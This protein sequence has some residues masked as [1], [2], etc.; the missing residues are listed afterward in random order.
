VKRFVEMHGGSVWVDS[1]P[2][3]GSIFFFTLPLDPQTFKVDNVL[4]TEIDDGLS[5]NGNLFPGRRDSLPE[6]EVPQNS[7]G[8]EPLVVIAEDDD[9]SRELLASVLLGAGYRVLPF[10]RGDLV[11][12]AVAKMHPYAIILDLMMPDVGGWEVL[13]ILRQHP[14]TESIPVIIV[15]ILDESSM[16]SRFNVTA[17]LT[18]P[19]DRGK[20]L[21]VLAEIGETGN[22]ISNILIVDDDPV[23]LDMLGTVLRSE[24]FNVSEA[25]GGREAIKKAEKELPDLIILDLMMPE[26]NG[27]DV[28]NA[29]KSGKGTAKI[30]I[31][32]FTAKDFDETF[33]FAGNVI[34]LLHK[35]SFSKRQLILIIEKLKHVRG[36]Q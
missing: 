20:L 5:G 29:L 3:S 9:A 16:E 13:Q 11:F 2:G 34:S 28:M 7:T 19:L 31:V 8:G 1:K 30:P 22:Q 32:I 27:F 26:V 33:E 15:S 36:E 6:I 21:S 23:V 17:H 14:E 18:K 24:G 10:S 4:T 25:G 35:G 12:Q